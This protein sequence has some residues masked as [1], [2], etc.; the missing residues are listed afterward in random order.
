MTEISDAK[1]ETVKKLQEAVG[2]S[3]IRLKIVKEINRKESI[4]RLHQRLKIPQ[5]TISR[6]IARF[7]TYGLVNYVRNDGKSEIYD[8]S[9]MLK[10]IGS[11]DKWLRVDLK[12]DQAEAQLSFK[13]IES[14]VR[15]P[16]GIPYIDFTT[17][18][19]ALRMTKPY[20][21]LFL[22]ENSLRNFI[23][24]TLSDKYGDDWWKKIGVKKEIVDRVEGR[25]KLES[26][27]K[28]H[29]PRGAHE[30]FYTDLEDLTYFLRKEPEFAARL[31]TTLWDVNIGTIVKLSRNIV[32]H[33]NPLPN[34]E[35]KRLQQI[36]EDWKRQLS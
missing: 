3:E 28:W 5:P 22:F 1:K 30:I 25:K 33:H 35:I 26:K 34:R 12:G 21:I 15:L 14:K 36:L 31:D 9:P 29:V 11:F 2:P 4:N 32:D 24:K 18:S 8:K 20:A 23:V 17:E 13:K 7:E 19:D 6:A 10:Q 27:H 16:V